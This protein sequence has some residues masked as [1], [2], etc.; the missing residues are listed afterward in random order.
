MTQIFLHKNFANYSES[1]NASFSMYQGCYV[2]LPCDMHAC[3]T[4]HVRI[5]YLSSHTA[6]MPP[7][8]MVQY[9]HVTY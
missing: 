8:L 1:Y 3:T 5:L 4:E 6:Y 9:M 2:R 7:T